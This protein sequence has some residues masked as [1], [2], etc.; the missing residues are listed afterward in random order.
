M[1]GKRGRRKSKEERDNYNFMY[2]KKSGI[3]K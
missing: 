1:E 3:E 2:I